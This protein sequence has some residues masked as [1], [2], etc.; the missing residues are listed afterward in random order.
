MTEYSYRAE[1]RRGPAGASTP[2]DAGQVLSAA[3][4]LAWEELEERAQQLAREACAEGDWSAYEAGEL[5]ALLAEL[6]ERE[7]GWPR[8][9]WS[10]LPSA[11]EGSELLLV[12][13]PEGTCRSERARLERPEQRG[14]RRPRPEPLK[15]R[16]LR[17]PAEL[18]PAHGQVRV[19]LPDRL[20]LGCWAELLTADREAGRATAELPSGES[21]TLLF[22]GEPGALY[23]LSEAEAAP[24]TGALAEGLAA[25][26]EAELE[27][28]EEACRKLRESVGRELGE[29]LSRSELLA[30]VRRELPLPL[31]VAGGHLEAELREEVELERQQL[32]RYRQAVARGEARAAEAERLYAERSGAANGGYLAWYLEEAELPAGGLGA[33]LREEVQARLTGQAEGEG[34]KLAYGEATSEPYLWR[35]RVGA[36]ICSGGA[37]D[38]EQESWSRYLLFISS[39]EA[40]SYLRGLR[41]L[42]VE[43]LAQELEEQ[44]PSLLRAS[45]RQAAE[46]ALAYL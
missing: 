19:R 44:A 22:T 8:S 6:G 3:A 13:S 12:V 45:A 17:L 41:E 15:L 5:S 46:Q 9:F 42:D 16:E 7:A 30:R 33:E 20:G 10:H 14:P 29:P 40:E 39:A 23:Q 24:L 35:G 28:R 2:A 18:A 1:V 4:G 11:E 36:V 27:Q 21:V 25:E 34:L 26:Q 43:L 32:A 37:L 31:G 38:G